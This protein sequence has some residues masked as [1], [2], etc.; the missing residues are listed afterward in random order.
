MNTTPNQ[1]SEEHKT[2]ILSGRGLGSY[3]PAS[4]NAGGSRRKSRSSSTTSISTPKRNWATAAAHAIGRKGRRNATFAFGSA[5][6]GWTEGISSIGVIRRAT[7][8]PNT[9]YDHLFVRYASQTLDYSKFPSFSWRLGW[10][11]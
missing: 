10:N 3:E 6:I 7:S 8:Q 9:K 11:G 4:K 1:I 5:S 2:V